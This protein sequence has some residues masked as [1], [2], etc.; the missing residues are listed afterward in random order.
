MLANKRAGVEVLR[1]PRCPV[2]Q[3]CD[4]ILQLPTA[5][6]LDSAVATFRREGFICLERSTSSEIAC[7]AASH[8]GKPCQGLPDAGRVSEATVSRL[9][10]RAQAERLA[11]R[12]SW[13]RAAPSWTIC[14]MRNP[15]PPLLWLPTGLKNLVRV[16]A[17][18]WLQCATTTH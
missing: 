13:T 7:T 10:V 9:Q 1:S 8:F 14:Y 2:L 18:C 4:S 3:G 11:P 12:L 6:P 17:V 15:S 16:A 5:L